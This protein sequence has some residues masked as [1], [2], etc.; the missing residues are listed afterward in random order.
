M[1]M[2]CCVLSVDG[3]EEK[4]KVMERCTQCDWKVSINLEKFGPGGLRMRVLLLY[5]L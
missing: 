4:K 3:I 1:C 2:Y 5:N